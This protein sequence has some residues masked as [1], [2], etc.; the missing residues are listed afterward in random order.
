MLSS[1]CSLRARCQ[2][3]GGTSLRQAANSNC[4]RAS[5]RQ[6][7]ARP[8]QIK[9]TLRGGQVCGGRSGRDELTQANRKGGQILFEQSSNVEL[10]GSEQLGCRAKA[11]RQLINLDAPQVR[12]CSHLR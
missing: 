8:G 4:N 12:E 3:I 11:R 6:D 5:R 1:V 9:P 7:Q 10:A 2:L